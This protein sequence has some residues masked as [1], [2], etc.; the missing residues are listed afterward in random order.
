MD[1]KQFV[2]S[3]YHG[4]VIGGLDVIWANAK[5]HVDGSKV[6]YFTTD[7]VYALV[8]CRKQSENFVTMGPSRNGKQHYFERFPDQLKVLYEGKEGFLYQPVEVASLTNAKGHTW[9]SPVDVPVILKEHISNV[10]KEI[11]READA[12]NVII[13]RYDEI[14]PAEQKMHANNIRDW[15]FS[16]DPPEYKDFLQKHFAA[17]WD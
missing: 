12:G 16:D 8:C 3:L 1:N 14:D 2:S 6:A 5:S 4:S 13:H 11:L 17:L 10:Y 15:I 9:E 7:R